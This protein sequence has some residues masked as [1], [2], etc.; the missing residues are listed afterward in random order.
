MNL[1]TS[2][3]P[4][5]ILLTGLVLISAFFLFQLFTN[6]RIGKINDMEKQVA[7]LDAKIE[8]LK[9]E[10]AQLKKTILNIK[11]DD[12]LIEKI[13]REDLGLIKDDEIVYRLYQ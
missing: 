9:T 1:I 7:H 13:A 10:N 12:Y 5:R 3:R 6:D 8:E 4:S 11:K 2:L